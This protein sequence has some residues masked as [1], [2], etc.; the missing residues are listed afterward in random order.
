MNRNKKGIMPEITRKVYRDV[1]KYDKQQFA[2]FCRSL[3]GFGY[4]DGRESVPGVD[5]EKIIEAIAATKGIGPKKL[6]EI[7]ANI[8][9]VLREIEN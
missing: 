8:D 1:K 2:S 9:A 7:R 3:Y 4:E 5:V 6:A